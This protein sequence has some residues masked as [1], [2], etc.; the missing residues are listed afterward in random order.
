VSS[1]N[2]VQLIGRLG[3]DPEI[4]YTGSGKAVA[5]FSIATEEKWKNQAGEKQSKTEWHRCVAWG[6]LAEIIQ[7]Y[8]KKGNLIFV[9]GRIET[10]KWEDRDKI[11]R[12]S[13]EIV[14]DKMQMLGSKN[15]GANRPEAPAREDADFDAPGGERV[16]QPAQTESVQ[17]G[18]VGG[19]EVDDSDIPF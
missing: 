8:V 5:N 16:S 15:D 18:Y 7:N 3:K 2:Q 12:Y 14:V 11:T 19:S 13:T 10:R 6:K 9:Q 17:P 4:K 1:L